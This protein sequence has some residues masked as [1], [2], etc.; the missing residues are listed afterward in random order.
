MF[1]WT[2]SKRRFIG[3]LCIAFAITVVVGLFLN[4]NMSV[5]KSN[6]KLPI[7]SVDTTNK[8]IA[9]TFDAAWTNQDTQDLIDILKKHNAK[10]TFFVVGD[11]AE[12]FPESVKAFH[13]AGHT[14]ANHSDTHKAFSKCK[15]EEIKVEIVNC[16]KK[17]E[18]ITGKPVT[19]VRAP[20][21]DYTDQSLDVCKELNMT[22]IQWNCD[23]LDTKVKL[24]YTIFRK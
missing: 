8:K 10:A 24:I 12:K 7:Y 4:E 22:M 20:S 11:W 13:D 1:M 3:L 9:I 14:I 23:I 2:V 18:A 16:N 5:A 15:R 19:L 6:R 21:G 17:L